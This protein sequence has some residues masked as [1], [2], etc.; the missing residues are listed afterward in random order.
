VWGNV[1]AS[2]LAT[3]LMGMQVVIDPV[4]NNQ[5]VLSASY[6]ASDKTLHVSWPLVDT[7]GESRSALAFLLVHYATRG[8]M[9]QTG[10]FPVGDFAGDPAGAADLVGLA[11]LALAGMDPGGMSDFY[12][13]L[14]WA[15]IGSQQG[16]NLQLDAA[17]QAEFSFPNFTP[18]VTKV[19]REVA[20][21]CVDPTNTPADIEACQVLHTLW[22][23][24]MPPGV[25]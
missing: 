3:A 25:L 2:Q 1:T 17:L 19:W 13:R 14:Q 15:M 24:H 7:L 22:Y 16:W 21:A 18:R 11:A 10:S 8:V 6:Q 12:G 4:V 20:D 9:V 5:Y 23:S